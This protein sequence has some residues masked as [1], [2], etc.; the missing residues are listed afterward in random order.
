MAGG[1]IGLLLSLIYQG[2]IMIKQIMGQ[3]LDGGPL[4]LVGVITSNAKRVAAY[5]ARHDLVQLSV[6]IPVQV[7]LAFEEYLKFKDLTKREVIT[8]LIETQLLRKR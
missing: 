6:D 3:P 2:A 1:A 8:K 5:R 7:M 4:V